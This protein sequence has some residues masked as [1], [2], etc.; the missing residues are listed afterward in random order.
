MVIDLGRLI[1]STLT[2]WVCICCTHYTRS[3]APN[4]HSKPKLFQEGYRQMSAVQ[5]MKK[6]CWKKRRKKN[7]YNIVKIWKINE[8]FNEKW[9]WMFLN[10]RLL[11]MLCDRSTI[12]FVVVCLLFFL[13]QFKHSSSSSF[14]SFF[15]VLCMWFFFWVIFQ[16]TNIFWCILRIFFSL[17]FLISHFPLHP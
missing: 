3:H 7:T 17:H 12:H 5:W 14:H 4:F 2:K 1:T 16:D 15:C 8:N 10:I 6:K 9:P 11:Q 13:Y